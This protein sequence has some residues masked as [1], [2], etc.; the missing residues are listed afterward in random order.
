MKKLIVIL[1]SAAFVF[2]CQTKPQQFFTASPEIELIKKANAAYE[3]GDWKTMR[4]IYSDTAKVYNNTWD[5]AS[6]SSPDDFLNGL[7]A[8][9]EKY[10]EY[11]LS[12]DAVYEM[13]VTD[14]GQKWVHNWFVWKGKTK[15]GLEVQMPINLSFLIVDGKVVLQSNIYNVLPA[16]LAEH[17]MPVADATPLK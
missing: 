9:L 5:M 17:P 3:A 16:Y 1:A 7:R 14:Q 11:D 2:S 15:N 6:V 10:N 13:I 8:T 12:D 4:A